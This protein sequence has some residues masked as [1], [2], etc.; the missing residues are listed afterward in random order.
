M[1]VDVD[2][3]G[4]IDI[5]TWLARCRTMVAPRLKEV[6]VAD[7]ERTTGAVDGRKQVNEHTYMH[8]HGGT[9]TCTTSDIFGLYH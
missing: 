9:D 4:K 1:R 7:S 6:L 8:I 5:D 3:D 2:G